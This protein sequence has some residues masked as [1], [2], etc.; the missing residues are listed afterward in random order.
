M[1]SKSYL[2]GEIYFLVTVRDVTF[3]ANEKALIRSICVLKKCSTLSIYK[4]ILIK[5]LVHFCSQDVV[6]LLSGMDGNGAGHGQNSLY[7]I[8]T[9]SWSDI[10]APDN[11]RYIARVFGFVIKQL[12]A[13]IC[14][15]VIISAD[16]KKMYIYR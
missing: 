1:A 15:V 6:V 9:N 16:D 11:S 13:T 4:N 8:R 5:R 14:D 7:D 3:S 12:D 2:K 10:S